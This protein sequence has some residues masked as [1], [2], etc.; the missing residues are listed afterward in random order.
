[1]PE[2]TRVVDVGAGMG[3]LSR[4]LSDAGYRVSACDLFPEYFR[5]PEVECLLVDNDGRLPYDDQS[6]D[7]AF[8]VELVEHLEETEHLFS[9]VARILK[10]GGELIIT[11]PNI[12]SLKSRLGFLFTG[13]TYSFPPLDPDVRDPV[14]QHITPLTLDGYRWRLKQ[15]GFEI[16]EV[17]VDKFQNTSMWLSFLL[18]FVW[19]ARLRA[20]GKSP[21]VRY[22][23][24]AKMLYGRTLMIRAR[25]A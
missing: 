25:K 15:A 6:L 14:H 12:L 9:E 17:A 3:A 18:P 8:G 5:V 2:V 1:M 7:V 22:Q 24:E 13:Y 11:T 20:S 21:N 10:P 4:R 23:N 16:E 19:F